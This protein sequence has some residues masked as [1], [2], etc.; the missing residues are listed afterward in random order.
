MTGEI[1]INNLSENAHK[2]EF[3][4]AFMCDGELWYWGAYR[5]VWSAAASSSTMS[6]SAATKRTE[7]ISPLFYNLLGFV[8][9][10]KRQFFSGPASEVLGRVFAC[11]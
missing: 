9:M 2:Y 8:K 7:K 1:N 6:E 10:H 5:F 3:I 11:N 4:V